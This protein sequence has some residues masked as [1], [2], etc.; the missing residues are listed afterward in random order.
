MVRYPILPQIER[1]QRGWRNARHARRQI[2]YI[3]DAQLFTPRDLDISP[4]FRIVKPLLE[5]GFDPH[6]LQW[7]HPAAETA[8]AKEGIT[9]SSGPVRERVSPGHPPAA[10][11]PDAS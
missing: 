11:D 2:L 7:A 4:Y 5:W 8:H 9:P 1:A 10:E 6:H 3:R